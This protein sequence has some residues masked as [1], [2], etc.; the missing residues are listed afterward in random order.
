M[1]REPM[2]N[3]MNQVM[4]NSSS[5]LLFSEVLDKVHKAKT[6]AQKVKILREHNNASL[7]MVIKS[8]F[9]P[10]IEWSMPEGEVPFMPNDAPA[11]TDHT[12]LATEAKKLYHF[13]KG[14]DGTTPRTKKEAMFI[15][16]LEGLH[17]SEAKLIVA[18]KDKKLHQ[19][20]KGLSKDVVKEAFNW[21]DDF[22]N[23]QLK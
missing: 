13:I 22:V 16:M 12:R 8:S 5:T 14:G 9:D 18:A 15:Q 23:P 19:I 10:K 7:R 2:R 17:E 21:N 4:D 11:G 20:Y 6:K 1:S 3:N